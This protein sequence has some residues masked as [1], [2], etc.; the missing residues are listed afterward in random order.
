MA[1]LFRCTR[2]S[3]ALLVMDMKHTNISSAIYFIKNK[4]NL[5]VQVIVKYS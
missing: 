4:K 1:N 2:L 3:K 5:N